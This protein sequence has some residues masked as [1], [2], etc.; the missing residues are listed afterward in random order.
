MD[1]ETVWWTT[2]GKIG[3]PPIARVMGV[4]RQQHA[5][6]CAHTVPNLSAVFGVNCGLFIFVVTI[7]WKH[8][9]VWVLLLFCIYE[10][11]FPFVFFG[12]D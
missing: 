2:S 9:R 3:L 7:L 8:T 5:V 10:V 1:G 4:G 6:G 11:S 12:F